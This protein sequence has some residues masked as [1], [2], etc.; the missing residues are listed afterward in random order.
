L[1]EYQARRWDDALESWHKSLALSEHHLVDILGLAGP[2]LA[3]PGTVEKLFPESSV[4]LIRAAKYLQGEKYRGE[5]SRV[6]DYAASLIPASNLP[7]AEQHYLGGVVL[8]LQG[9]PPAAVLE[10][11]HAVELAPQETPWRYE[12]ARLLQSQGRLTEAH[13]HAQMC[14]AV[15]PDRQEYRE[16]LQAISVADARRQ[17]SN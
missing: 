13:K 3:A 10:Y 6:L 16:L 17:V 2:R 8:A 1:V 15:E 12:L 4:L 7:K 9:R 11:S 14:V 5:Q